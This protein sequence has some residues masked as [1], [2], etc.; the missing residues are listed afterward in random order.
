MYI[1]FHLITFSSG[2]TTEYL[3]LCKLLKA[4]AAVAASPQ[5]Q[6]TALES[7]SNTLTSGFES[8]AEVASRGTS[9]GLTTLFLLMKTVV[10]F[11]L[12][13][14]SVLR[15]RG[16]S[17]SSLAFVSTSRPAA[18]RTSMTLCCTCSPPDGVTN[19]SLEISW[20]EVRTENSSSR[21]ESYCKY[22]TD[23]RQCVG[24]LR[25]SRCKL[26]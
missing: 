18:L 8:A 15:S 25:V 12:K 19:T 23:I 3:K 13:T 22:D 20:N 6:N 9:S 5:D 16:L 7:Y 10:V 21:F 4:A 2:T 14:L 24:N 11:E 1:S 26:T 17:V